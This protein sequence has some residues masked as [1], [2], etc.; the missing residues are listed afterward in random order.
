VSGLIPPHDGI[1]WVDMPDGIHQ[2]GTR[3]TEGDG[4][5]VTVEG[6]VRVK[7]GMWSIDDPQ[8]VFPLR[9]FGHDD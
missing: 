6:F 1:K 8:A 7:P 3:I 5:T 4:D 9:E 2:K